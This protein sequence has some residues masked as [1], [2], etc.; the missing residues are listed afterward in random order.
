VDALRHSE[1]QLRSVIGT[2][3]D[4]HV[5]IID[6]QSC[7]PAAERL[8]HHSSAEVRGRT[9]SMLMPL[10]YRE[11][12]DDYLARCLHTSVQRIIGIGR[13]AGGQR[14]PFPMELAVGDARLPGRLA[15]P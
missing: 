5:I 12:H 15:T 14:A 10:P 9:L 4:T 7:S 13:I 3:P 2:V 8:F 1:A 6:E 11:R